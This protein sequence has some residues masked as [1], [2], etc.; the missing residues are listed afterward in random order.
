MSGEKDPVIRSINET[1][2]EYKRLGKSGLR[3]SVPIL[4]AMSFG[5]KDW[6]PWVIEEDEAL[7]LLKAAYDRG[8]NTW[9]TA[10]VSGSYCTAL[11][12]LIAC[13]GLLQWRQRRDNRQGNQE[14]QHPTQQARHPVQVSRL[15]RRNT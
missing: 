13:A 12:R 11:A 6:Q 5:T 8:L 15:R 3:V 14:I 2:V 10:N 9:D 1:K 7:P 4:G